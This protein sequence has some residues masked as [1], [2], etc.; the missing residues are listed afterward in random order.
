MATE[1]NASGGPGTE[2]MAWRTK[3]RRS[4]TPRVTYRM[5]PDGEVEIEAEGYGADDAVGIVLALRRPLDT[6]ERKE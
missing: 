5:M 6:T 3:E 1:R 2:G 4:T